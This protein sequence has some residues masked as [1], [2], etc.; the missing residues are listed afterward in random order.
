VADSVVVLARGR[1]MGEFS[2][3]EANYAEVTELV[4]RG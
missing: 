3:A 1:V 4:A 2:A